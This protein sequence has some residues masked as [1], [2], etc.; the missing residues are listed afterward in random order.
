MP[1]C[2]AAGGNPDDGDDDDDDDDDDGDPNNLDYFEEEASIVLTLYLRQ[3]LFPHLGIFSPQGKLANAE[4]S[5]SKI[6][7]FP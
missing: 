5:W 3:V 4:N 6:P 1:H 2:S 7:K